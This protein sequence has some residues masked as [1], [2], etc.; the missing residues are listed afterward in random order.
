MIYYLIVN[1]ESKVVFSTTDKRKAD[2]YVSKRPY[3]RVSEFDDSGVNNRPFKD[4][5]F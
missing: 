2:E 4:L 5:D 1:K 3:L